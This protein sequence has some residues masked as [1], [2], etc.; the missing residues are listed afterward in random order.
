[1]FGKRQFQ[2][3]GKKCSGWPHDKRSSSTAAGS[4]NVDDFKL[5]SD[6]VH[7]E[8]TQATKVEKNWHKSEDCRKLL[9]FILVHLKQPT[10]FMSVFNYCWVV[11]TRL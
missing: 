3:L 4:A 7:R 5:I 9:L 2:E 11:L 10:N 1:M 8:V 6:E